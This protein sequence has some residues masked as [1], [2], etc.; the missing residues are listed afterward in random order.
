MYFKGEDDEKQQENTWSRVQPAA[1]DS[2]GGGMF[3]PS[4]D[5]DGQQNQRLVHAG[6]SPSGGKPGGAACKY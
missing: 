1:P 3:P 2:G 4:F 6:A 5:Q